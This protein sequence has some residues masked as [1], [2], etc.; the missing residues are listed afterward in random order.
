MQTVNNGDT[1]TIGEGY[2][3]PVVA[4][5]TARAAA[6]PISVG[7]ANSKTHS[8][9]NAGDV[10]ESSG[11]YYRYVGSAALTN[12]DFEIGAT[13]PDFTST[14]N[15][16]P[17][18]IQIGGTDGHVYQYIGAA[19]A[20]LDLN[21]QDFTNANLWSDITGGSSEGGSGSESAPSGDTPS[22]GA[23]LGA[24]SGGSGDTSS[25]KT[26]SGATNPSGASNP[27]KPAT[28]TTA[29]QGSESKSSGNSSGLSFTA[30]GVYTENKISAAIS[31][32]VQN[33]TTITIGHAPQAGLSVT[34][35]DAATIN[36]LDGAAA[37]SGNFSGSGSTDAISIGIGIARNTIRDAVS[38]S[39]LNAG[40]IAAAGAPMTISA[41]QDDQI[42]ATSV[43]ASLAIS[44]SNQNALSVAG[45][46][47]LADNLIGA[48][49][50]ATSVGHAGRPVR[51]LGRRLERH[52]RRYVQHPRDG[53]RGLRCRFVLQPERDRGRHRRLARP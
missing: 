53:R 46:A 11:T 45:G 14:S 15:G 3:D 28:S 51:R 9:V 7:S 8:T 17:N 1:V 18:W 24:L 33:T 44:A 47:S 23:G 42:Q 37:V 32:T 34:A 10:V 52:R 31:A 39:V 50:S 13:P 5:A 20:S 35:S 30:A 49:T 29:T 6:R 19:A 38:A 4:V 26:P 36:S 12:V 21:N 43:A 22:V 2:I 25:E 40:T 41:T 27:D 16:Q 48:N